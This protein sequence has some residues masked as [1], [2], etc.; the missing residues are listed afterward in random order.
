MNQ[1]IPVA[2]RTLTALPT[3][4]QP[5]AALLVPDQVARMLRDR[6]KFS[7]IKFRTTCSD[8]VPNL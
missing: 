3:T 8:C 6:E 2:D 4:A 7:V 1:V 5:I